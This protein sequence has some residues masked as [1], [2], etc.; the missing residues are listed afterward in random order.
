MVDTSAVAAVLF[1]G[2][3]ASQL[4]A[5]IAER[6]DAAKRPFVEELR[7]LLTRLHE[8]KN[9]GSYEENARA[10]REVYTLAKSCG[11]NLIYDGQ[12]VPL[13]CRKQAGIRT[14]LFRVRTLDSEQ[15]TLYQRVAFPVLDIAPVAE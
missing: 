7:G 13:S 4:V 10:A 11:M 5:D 6:H 12:P 8:A 14:G 1:S 15:R 3:T 2:S 9:L